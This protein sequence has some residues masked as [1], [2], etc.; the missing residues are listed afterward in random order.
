[1]TINIRQIQEARDVYAIDDWG[2]GFY[3]I[4][5][6]GEVACHP[7]AEKELS[8]SLLALTREARKRGARFPMIMRFPQIVDSQ[9][10]KLHEAFRDA[11]WEYNYLGKHFAVFP[12]KVNQRREFIDTVVK[13]GRAFRYGL[14]IGSK[15]EFMAALSYHLSEEALFICNGFKDEEFIELAY[16]AASMGKNI[17]V[18]VEGP[19]EL[20]WICQK[21]ARH[22]FSI[23]IGLRVKLYS[24]GSGK[25]V[26][27]SGERSKFG[28]TTS[29]VLTCLHIL[30][31]EGMADSL[32]MLHF[33]IGSQITEI[34]RF[35]N[36]IKEASQV[37]AKV[38]HMGFKPR[39]LNLGGG[40]GVDYDGSKTSFHSSAN[41]SLQEFTNDAVYT[42]GEVCSKE[43]VAVPDIVTES[44]RVVAAYHSIIVTD[45][46][47]IHGE[48]KKDLCQQYNVDMES[49]ETP[50]GIKELKYILENIDRK[51]F[52][53]YYHDA[54]EYHE[55]LFVLFNLGYITLVHRAIAEDLYQKIR[56]RA[57]FYSSLQRHQPEEFENLQKQILHK[58]LAN[59]SIFQSIPDSWGIDQLFPV[60]P[61]SRH[62]EK[63]S[64]KASIVDITCDSDGCLERF[65]DRRDIKD[66]LDLHASSDEPYYIGF[67]LIGAYQESLANEHNL[68]GAI[69]EVSVFL[70]QS[71]KWDLMGMTP[72]DHVGELLTT[73]NFEL[74]SILSSYRDQLKRS[75][76][77]LKFD[78]C[79]KKKSQEYLQKFLLNGYP[80][81]QQSS[82][83]SA[84][85]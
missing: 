58:Y 48:H 35:K 33:H 55:E 37:Y 39:F 36:A 31:E 15:P 16:I 24:R 44:G 66:A 3:S 38:I 49:S 84:S 53:E 12:F 60:L 42:I 18:V 7:T 17:H 26:R 74:E 64:R 54:V 82:V 47:E 65:I 63:P 23:G 69:D 83:P 34:T 80:Y 9:L 11:I 13:A 43:K 21:R 71:G 56:H 41:Y 2:A 70:N 29:E 8:V 25:W 78:D 76:E 57:S 19:E 14:E 59:F 32:T 51:N 72:G 75:Q 81:L 73:R 6:R 79:Y 4:N 61:L 27:S 77:T 85:K 5:N 45:V 1:V 46:R 30:E 68:F 50:P 40:I 52:S 10:R 28:L 67:F 62:D 22:P 20:E